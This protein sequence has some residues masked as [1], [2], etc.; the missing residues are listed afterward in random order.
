VNAVAR[1]RRAVLLGLASLVVPAVCAAQDLAPRAYLPLPV[2]SNALGLTYGFSRGEIV[3]DPT[4]PVTDA[5]GTIHAPV[6]TYYRAF[7]LFGRSANITGVLPF[8]VGSIRGKLNGEEG[9]A[10]RAGLADTVVRVAVNFKG[11]PALS[12]A[13]FVKTKP[14]R[15]VWGASLKVVMP[16]GQ[17][18]NA[19]LINIGAHRWAFKPELGYTG[20]IGHMMIDAYAGVWFFT[21]NND[22]FARDAQTPPNTRTQDPI[23]ALEFHASYD[24]KPRLWISADL[25]YWRGGRTSVNGIEPANTLQANSRLGVTGS[26]PLTRHQSLKFSFSDGVVVRVGGRFRIL[27]VGWQYGWIGTP[28]PRT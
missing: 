23:A 16:T 12:L 3:F 20:R 27:T 8:A 22:Y 14:P 11:G 26:V 15:S 2:S 17:Y 24:V 18:D 1:A 6:V 19:R 7:D 21:A 28:R 13:E 10:R 5:S 4:L 9:E 25:N